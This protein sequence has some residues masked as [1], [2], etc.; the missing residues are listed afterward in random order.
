MM[1]DLRNKTKFVMIVV[2]LAFVGLGI[3]ELVQRSLPAEPD[4]AR[5][6]TRHRLLLTACAAASN[7]PDLDLFLT[8]LLPAP[9]GYLLHHRGHTHTLLYALPQALL[10]LALLWALWPNA[11][12]LLAPLTD[13]E[14]RELLTARLVNSRDAD[15][16]IPGLT[17]GKLIDHIF[18]VERRHV[19]RLRGEAL[20]DRTGLT[21]NNAPPL[22][23]YGASVRRELEQLVGE[24]PVVRGSHSV[25]IATTYA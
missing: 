21:G 3:G 24:R 9:L 8:K 5:Q 19:Q 7:F 20:A 22:F 18:L 6:R 4:E 15:E 1:Q 23:D 25:R 12:R 13:D 14:S 10:L 11:R 2:A 16:A 17:V